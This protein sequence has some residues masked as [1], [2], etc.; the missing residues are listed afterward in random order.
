[1]AK[2][3]APQRPMASKHPGAEGNHMHM[4]PAEVKAPLG[5]KS[6]GTPMAAD[7]MN[8][9]AWGPL[10]P[11]AHRVETAVSSLLPATQVHSGEEK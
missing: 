3:T 5:E 4:P 11:H 2:V 10:T 7:N 8:S 1:M 6:Y 9:G